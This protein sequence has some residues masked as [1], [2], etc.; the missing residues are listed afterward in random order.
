[1]YAPVVGMIVDPASFDGADAGLITAC[2]TA[3]LE[4]MAS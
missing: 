2:G 3:N 1:M 4:R